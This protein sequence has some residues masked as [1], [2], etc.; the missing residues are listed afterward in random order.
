MDKLKE[1]DTVT[2]S[3]HLAPVMSRILDM[4]GLAVPLIAE[5]HQ[6]CHHQQTHP[7]AARSWS[8]YQEQA[9]FWEQLDF[10]PNQLEGHAGFPLPLTAWPG[11]NPGVP[12]SPSFQQP[13]DKGAGDD[14]MPGGPA[15]LKVKGPRLLDPWRGEQVHCLQEGSSACLCGG[16]EKVIC[17]SLNLGLSPGWTPGWKQA[18]E[19]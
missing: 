9:G 13:C 15:D 19:R 10:H 12:A 4:A 8:L 1:M 14:W 17:S 2:G 7:D 3:Q 11:G 18:G 5:L 16:T 6:N